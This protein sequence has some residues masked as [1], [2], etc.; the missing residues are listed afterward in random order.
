SFGRSVERCLGAGPTGIF[1]SGGL[2]SISVAAVATD[3]ARQLGQAL[4][5]ALSLD[6][7][8]PECGEGPRQAAVAR[9]LGLPQYLVGFQ[10]ALGGRGLFEQVIAINQGSAARFLG[11]YQ[12]A[13]AT[14][15]KRAKQ[16]GVRTILTGQGGDEALG[17][18]MLLAADLIRR[19]SF[20]GLA[21]FLG[22]LRRSYPLHPLL[23]ARNVLWRFG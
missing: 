16:E 11:V 17:L 12:P 13:Y 7:E 20:V 19:G 9:A 2:D 22:I 6:I 23:Q 1:L 10:E 21:K 8:D 5:W 14:L 3:R 18:S 15:T 4:P